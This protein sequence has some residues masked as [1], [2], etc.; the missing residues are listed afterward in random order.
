MINFNDLTIIGLADDVVLMA[1][2]KFPAFRL[3]ILDR[4]YLKFSNSTKYLRVKPSW[5][6]QLHDNTLTW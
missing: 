1:R 5:H 2:C 6:L 3:P 4:V